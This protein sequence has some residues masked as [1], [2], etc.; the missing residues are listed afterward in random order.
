MISTGIIFFSSNIS[1]LF[2]LWYCSII[3]KSLFLYLLKY[4]MSCYRMIIM[5]WI[6]TMDTWMYHTINQRNDCLKVKNQA[7]W[8]PNQTTWEFIKSV[9]V[10]KWLITWTLCSLSY[11]F[12]STHFMSASFPLNSSPNTWGKLRT[13]MSNIYFLG[14]KYNNT[15]TT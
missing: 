14:N 10:W 11:T 8:E 2:L 12:S 9:S 7:C 5:V 15:K 3:I 13:Y 6:F 4:L 1:V